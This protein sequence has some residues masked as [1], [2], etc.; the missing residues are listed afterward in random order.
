VRAER[1]TWAE[2]D[3][4]AIRHNIGIIRQLVGIGV[5]IMAV[6]KADAYGHGSA[7]VARTAVESGVDRLG[8]ATLTEAVEL[9]E[10]GVHSP[11]QILGC[12]FPEQAEDIVRYNIVQ[13]VSNEE[14]VR[15]LSRAATRARRIAR[16]HIKVDTGMGRVGVSEHELARFVRRASEYES[17]RIEAI[18]THLPCADEETDDFTPSQIERFRLLAADEA[19]KPLNVLL[20]AANSAAII[21]YPESHLNLVRPGLMLY[22]ATTL[23][24]CPIK[25]LLKPA[26]SLKS[27]IVQIRTMSKG[28]AVSYGRTYV[29][30]SDTAVATIPIGYA[31]GFSRML[32]GRAQVLVN[33]RRAPVIGRVCMD[34]C[35]V[36]IKD[37]GEARL[38]DIVTLIGTDNG[39]SIC[40]EEV[41][42]W[43]DSIPHEVL[44]TIGKRVQ[45]IYVS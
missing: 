27:R 18:M 16:V 14:I 7:A 25:P 45:R 1:S 10:A 5:E 6:V 2:I 44:C 20:H 33:G 31:D 13:T 43:A 37:A 38:G 24:D 40:A 19:I 42:D 12:S 30:S 21:R 32:S 28:E 22:G 3:L 4:S 8:V 23:S 11:I 34:Q 29:T 41:A 35:L 9:R 39:E 15:A 17:V 36:D 26:L